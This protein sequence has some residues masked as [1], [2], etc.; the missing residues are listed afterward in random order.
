[1]VYGI[2]VLGGALLPTIA[3]MMGKIVPFLTW[4]RAYGPKVGRQPTPPATALSHPRLEAWALRLQTVAI[5]ALAAGAWWLNAPLLAIGGGLLAIGAGLFV[6]NLL[7]VLKH[8]WRPVSPQ[9]R[10]R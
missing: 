6:A 3:G 5:L 4:M 9:P 2:L 8:L 10:S 7:L 1:M